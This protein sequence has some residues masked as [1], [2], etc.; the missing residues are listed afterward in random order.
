MYKSVRYRSRKKQSLLFNLLVGLILML[1][2]SSM[3]L[4]LLNSN[5]PTLDNINEAAGKTI[6]VE[7][8][9]NLQEIINNAGVSDAIFFNP[10]EYLIQSPLKIRD[11]KIRILGSGE[12]YTII[13]A[14]NS[15]NKNNIL[16]IENSEITIQ[17][18]SI[19][20]SES[21][22]INVIGNSKLNII[23][24]TIS[25]N[26]KS[27][28]K[29][30]GTNL[31]IQRSKLQDNGTGIEIENG[32]SYIYS[33]I[34]KNNAKDGILIKS[35]TNTKLQNLI[36]DNNKEAGIKI[37]NGNEIE[38][39]NI[40]LINNNI[41]IL[42]DNNT[43]KTTILNTIIQGNT[44]EGLRLNSNST[45]RYSSFYRNG[46][47]NITPQSLNIGEGNIFQDANFIS[48]TDYRLSPNSP[49][50]DKGIPTEFDNDGTRID[51]G[52]FGGSNILPSQNN[53]P[54]VKSKPIEYI[55]PN[56]R[57]RYE[58]I[59]EDIDGDSLSYI[60]M[61]TLPNWLKLE[62]N[63]LE[64]TP[65][66]KDIGFYGI[67]IVISDRKG[68]N[69]VHAI[70]INVLP[71]QASSPS[72]P[73][74][75]PTPT[76]TNTPINTQTPTPTP[77]IVIPRIQIIS[78]KQDDVFTP[79]N[80]VI[81]WEIQPE[82]T[83]IEKIKISYSS[84]GDKYELIKELPGSSMSYIWDEIENLVAGKYFIKIQAIDSRNPNLEIATI[85][86]QFEIQPK[87][88]TQ[89]LI[90]ITKN[91][92]SDNDVV[93][94]NK[95][96]IVVEFKPEVELDKSQTRLIVA[97]Q[98]V[99]YR[100]TKNTIYYQPAQPYNTSRVKVEVFLVTKDG[101]T[102]SKQWIF[103]IEESVNPADTNPDVIV[104]TQI[105]IPGTR[106]CIPQIIGT[107]CIGIIV[108]LLLVLIM[109]FVIRI[110][111]NIRDQ[112]QG[113]IENEFSDFYGEQGIIENISDNQ[114]N[115][116]SQINKPI[117]PNETNELINYNDYI[118]PQNQNIPPNNQDNT[119]I[120]QIIESNL[121][122]TQNNSTPNIPTN[123]Q[124][125]NFEYDQNLLNTQIQ[126]ENNISNEP[127][128]SSTT[129]TTFNEINPINHSDLSSNV[130]PS[131]IYNNT[132]NIQQTDDTEYIKS[133]MQKYGIQP[134]QNNDN[135]PTAPNTNNTENNQPNNT[136]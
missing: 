26:S 13:R 28:I 1:V 123:N 71:A 91:S 115:N 110:I 127:S 6:F 64:G 23:E 97:G 99:A 54:V 55:K 105:C 113:N 29:F 128:T 87:K 14:L 46:N 67:I 72:I 49:L 52:A 90:A 68:G 17:S 82:S 101:A 50:K 89:T 24:T 103:N 33:T 132:N 114:I 40:N 42:E 109:V 61:N 119:Q 56:Q 98:E 108:L 94:D 39:K 121:E 37:I 32:N 27:G 8:T 11:K 59:A 35:T 45:I 25:R 117:P 31:Q 93:K 76:V 79:E 92:P 63:I 65:E 80:N 85:S 57:Y 51:I 73:T 120:N 134:K 129:Q 130:K 19:I 126:A 12:D 3:V 2:L 10:G 133:L 47:T 124:A 116:E 74:S 111:K 48:S 5:K 58:I 7:P 125:V 135:I 43:S 38:I 60:V 81:K 102:A 22:G 100:T 77:T 44:T 86:S 112:R 118:I 96:Q 83:S 15:T 16:D 18:L 104:R 62:K 78:P 122:T 34:I 21:E 30:A 107:I 36:V 70:N 106:I 88:T 84:D 53:P 4:I 9:S 95:I 66:N 131:E 75:S 20:G 136:I 69:T 41:G